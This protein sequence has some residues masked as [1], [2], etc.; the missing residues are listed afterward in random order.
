MRALLAKVLL[1]ACST[2]HAQ[3]NDLVSWTDSYL[4]SLPPPQHFRGNLLVERNGQILMKKSYG[5]ADE[6]W[7]VPNEPDGRFEIA[8]LTKQFT[9]VAILQLAEAGKLSVRDF[10][11]KFFTQSPSRGR[12]SQLS[13]SSL[14][15]LDCR[16]MSSRIS[17]R[18]SPSRIPQRN[19]SRLFE[20]GLS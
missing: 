2:L 18:E 12:R 7:R 3:A 15:R 14:T 17:L 9:A 4:G 1:L 19:S 13:T 16:I 5:L 8:S 10:A 6:S 20:T 11:S